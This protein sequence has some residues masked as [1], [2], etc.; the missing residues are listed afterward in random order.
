MHGGNEL[1]LG[2]VLCCLLII[3]K[4]SYIIMHLN[5]LNNSSI[6]MNQ[7]EYI[8]YLEKKNL[9]TVSI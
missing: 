8:V 2:Y 4:K 7:I 6:Y 3:K 9:F 5:I 1:S